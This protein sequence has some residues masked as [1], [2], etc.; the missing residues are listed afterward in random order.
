MRKKTR[1]EHGTT[2]SAGWRDILGVLVI[3]AI[4]CL[5]ILLTVNRFS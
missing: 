1:L 4:A 3:L 2:D 5:A